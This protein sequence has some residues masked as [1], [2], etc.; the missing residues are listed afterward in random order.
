M[1]LIAGI[2]E[3]GM[4][5]LAG[6]VLAAAVILR[7]CCPIDGLAD[8]KQLT[9]RRREMLAEQIRQV[10]VAFAIGR[11][12]VWEIDRLNVLHAAW[13]AM[14]RAVAALCVAPTAVIIDGVHVPSFPC[15]ARAVVRGD[16]TVPAISAASIIAK[17]ARDAEMQAWDAIYPM[18]GFAAH[19]GYGTRQHVRALKEHGPC[20]LHRYSFAPVRDT[21]NRRAAFR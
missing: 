3:V 9:P 8:S 21:A 20:S 10:A 15:P 2:D 13:L 4:G 6:P 1:R 19:K 18:Y 14:Q 16:A 7:P 17:V 5:P 12:E 11:A